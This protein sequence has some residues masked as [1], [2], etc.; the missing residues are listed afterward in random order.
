MRV[1]VC[2]ASA[3]RLCSSFVSVFLILRDPI[4]RLIHFTFL[5]RV[6]SAYNYSTERYE[7]IVV[8]FTA[9][10]EFFLAPMR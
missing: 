9:M 3:S 10:R 7:T 1:C 2:C 5:G 6:N 4:G 8:A